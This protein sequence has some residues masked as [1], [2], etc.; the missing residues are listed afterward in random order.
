MALVDDL[1]TIRENLAT[2]VKAKTAEWVTDGCPVTYSVDGESYQWND[3]LKAKMDEIDA[4]TVTIQKLSSPF[5]VR[6][7]GR[8]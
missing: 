1:K 2:A 4:I 7:R 3:W 5:I 6:S 8:S